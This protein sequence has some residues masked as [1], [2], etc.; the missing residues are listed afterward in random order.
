[1]TGQIHAHWQA[2]F[3]RLGSHIGRNR[4]HVAIAWELL[5]AVWQLPTAR[6]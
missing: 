5:I 6:V 1:M 3:A 4:V 2:V